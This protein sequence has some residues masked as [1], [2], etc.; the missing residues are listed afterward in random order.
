MTQDTRPPAHNAIQL[1]R[2]NAF[3]DSIYGAFEEFS[4]QQVIDMTITLAKLYRAATD[5]DFTVPTQEEAAES[6]EAYVHEHEEDGDTVVYLPTDLGYYLVA[7]PNYGE[8]PIVIERVKAAGEQWVDCSDA[9][10][11]TDDE[12]RAHMPLTRLY[13]PSQIRALA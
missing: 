7:D 6:F 4:V 12:V 9:H 3:S 5:E 10:Y 1:R 8:G 11:L 2:F 13:T